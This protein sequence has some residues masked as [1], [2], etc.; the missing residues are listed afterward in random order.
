MTQPRPASASSAKRLLSNIERDLK[1]RLRRTKDGDRLDLLLARARHVVT[2]GMIPSGA[3]GYPTTTPGNGNVGGR[4]GRHIIVEDENGQPDRVPITSTEAAAL[5]N[6]SEPDP[7]ATIARTVVTELA[8]IKAAF[9]SLE[10]ALD[11]FDGL[12]SAATVNDPPQCY[13]ASKVH[14]LPWDVTWEP[15]RK[16]TMNGTYDEPVDVCKFTYWFH[17]NNGRLPSKNEMLRHLERG[18]VMI[19]A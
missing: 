5:A 4:G 13:V 14:R 10:S 3:D 7:V 8:M 15:F 19:N 1:Y 2:V 18:V 9:D 11:R 16:S 6:V 17:R 12:R